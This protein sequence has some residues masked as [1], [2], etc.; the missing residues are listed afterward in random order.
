MNH[1]YRISH[2]LLRCVCK[3]YPQYIF[4][5]FCMCLSQ[6]CSYLNSIA[7]FNNTDSVIEV[8]NLNLKTPACYVALPKSLIKISLAGD[9]PLDA[10]HLKINKAQK[11]SHYKLKFSPSFQYKSNIYCSRI[12]SEKCDIT[13]Q[14]EENSL[15]YWGGRSKTLPIQDFP[16]QPI[17]FPVNALQN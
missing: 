2:S 7:L 17:G 8:C 12:I 1:L 9:I 3:S 15:L 14:Y 4:F 16:E 5:I 11:T 13:I 6:G 10:W